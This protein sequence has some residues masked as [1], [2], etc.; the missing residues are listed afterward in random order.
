M[1]SR[2]VGMAQAMSSGKQ[3]EMYHS[4]SCK[5]VREYVSACVRASVRE[6]ASHLVPLALL[7]RPT[8]GQDAVARS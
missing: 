3:Q 6:E 2:A 4:K 1:R 7:D 8:D 5:Q